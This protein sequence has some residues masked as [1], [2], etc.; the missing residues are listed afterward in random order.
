M[1]ASPSM[2][3]QDVWPSRIERAKEVIHQFVQRETEV[4]RF[5]LV[6]FSESSVILSYLTSDPQNLLFYLDFLRP[7]RRILYGTDIGVAL[8]SGLQVLEKHEQREGS[9]RLR[10]EFTLWVWA[11]PLNR[12]WAL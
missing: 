6:S 5:G 8:S 7:D 1:D 4:V 11:C 2:N 10:P 12:S 9:D 3:T